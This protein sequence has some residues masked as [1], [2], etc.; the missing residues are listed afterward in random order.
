MM[1]HNFLFNIQ[2]CG[3]MISQR[4][5]QHNGPQGTFHLEWE[6]NTKDFFNF[7]FPSVIV[8]NAFNVL[9][10]IWCSHKCLRYFVWCK[11]MIVKKYL[12]HVAIQ[13]I[14]QIF[15]L[16]ICAQCIERIGTRVFF[17]QFCDIKNLA[18]FFRKLGKIDRIYT[19][20]KEKFQNF[21]KRFQI[22]DKICW[23]K[24]KHWLELVSS[25]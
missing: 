4:L 8:S 3:L 23:G 22:N 15:H 2:C 21:P 24:R 7:F 12:E 18:K 6:L 5:E 13:L 1:A 9:N 14:V 19:R 17:F 20:R 25:F 11:F 10:T 16:I